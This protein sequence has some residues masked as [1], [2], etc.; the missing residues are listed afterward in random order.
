M[1]M[2]SVRGI[3]H[4]IECSDGEP[5]K[6][7]PPLA[8]PVTENFVQFSLADAEFR[9]CYFQSL[10]GCTVVFMSCFP[11]FRLTLF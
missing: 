2:R 1:C 8:Y 3:I 10:V 6:W 7:E 4:N 11:G 5:H 9:I